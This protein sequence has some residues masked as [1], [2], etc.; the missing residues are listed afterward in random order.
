MKKR[1]CQTKAASSASFARMSTCWSLEFMTG[2]QSPYARLQLPDKMVSHVDI[3]MLNAPP[4]VWLHC[5][6]SHAL[7]TGYTGTSPKLYE[8][9]NTLVNKVDF[10]PCAIATYSI[11][12]LERFKIREV[13]R[14]A[15]KKHS[16]L[17]Y[18]LTSR[19]L[20][21]LN[22]HNSNYQRSVRQRILR[23]SN[24]IPLRTSVPV[25]SSQTGTK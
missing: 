13:L 18:R 9:N 16:I 5:Y 23:A 22:A 2:C 8:Y 15:T 24:H 12:V 1:G 21:T 3:S 20:L 6:D 10:V 11:S 14:S 17:L 25:S 4:A 7:H 19:Q